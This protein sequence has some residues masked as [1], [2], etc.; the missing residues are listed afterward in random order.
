MKKTDLKSHPENYN[1]A[2]MDPETKSTR[3]SGLIGRFFHSIKDGRLQWQGYVRSR[4]EPGWYV[5]QLYEWMGGSPNIQ[6]LVRIEAMEDWFFYQNA[7]E[8]MHSWEHGPCRE[9]GKYN[10]SPAPVTPAKPV[11]P[12]LAKE[13]FAK[14]KEAAQ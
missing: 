12:E 10:P 4:P 8:M 6:R 7:E 11:P 14:M 13:L 1:D 5:I 3:V 9:G 2:E